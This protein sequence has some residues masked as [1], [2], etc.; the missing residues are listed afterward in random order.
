MAILDGVPV[1]ANETTICRAAELLLVEADECGLRGRPWSLAELARLDAADHKWLTEWGQA[2]TGSVARR[3]LDSW[4]HV[5]VAGESHELSAVTGLLFFVLISETARREAREGGLWS[6]VVKGIYEDS[7]PPSSVFQ[8]GQPSQFLKDAL[9]AAAVAFGLRHLFGQLG[10][11]NWFD[12]VYLQ[13][14]FTRAG[15]ERRL[16][17]WL[18]GQ[19]ATIAITSLRD[20]G[21]LFSKSFGGLWQ[22]LRGYRTNNLPLERCRSIVS[23]SPWTLPEWTDNLIAQARSRI[24]LAD[25]SKS[26]EFDEPPRVFLAEPRLVWSTPNAP[27]FLTEVSGLADFDLESPSYSIAIG[28]KVVSSLQRRADSTYAIL[29]ADATIVIENPQPSMQA[30]LLDAQGSAESALE[31]KLWDDDEDITV[32]RAV[33]ADGSLKCRRIPDAYGSKLSPDQSY[34]LL[35]ASDLMPRFE[36]DYRWEFADG[37]FVAYYVAKGW[38]MER[39]ALDLDGELLWRPATSIKGRS[40]EPEWSRNVRVLPPSR[41]VRVGQQVALRLQHSDDVEVLFVRCHSKPLDFSLSGDRTCSV[42]PITVGVGRDDSLLKM[43]IGLRRGGDHCVVRRRLDVPTHGVAFLG[44]TGWEALPEDEPLDARVARAVPFRIIPPSDDGETADTDWGL[45]EGDTYLRLV[46][47][48]PRPIGGVAGLGAPL[49][50]KRGPYNSIDP[51]M[52][53]AVAVVD[54]G[55]VKGVVRGAGRP[56]FALLV[57]TSIEPGND[58][59]VLWW[60]SLGRLHRCS[61]ELAN[62]A[63]EDLTTIWRCDLDGG[64]SSH[65]AVG[66]AYAGARVG[67]CWSADWPQRLPEAFAADPRAT[68]ALLR[69]FRLPLLDP[70]AVNSI[71]ALVHDHAASCAEA[72]LLDDHL[73]DGLQHQASEQGWFGAV[74]LLMKKARLDPAGLASVTSA[75]MTADE[76]PQEAFER[77]VRQLTRVD[78]FLMARCVGAWWREEGLRVHGRSWAEQMTTRVTCQL[79]GLDPRACGP[80]ADVKMRRLLIKQAAAEMG[81]DSAFVRDGLLKPCLASWQTGEYSNGVDKANV[82]LAMSIEPFRRLVASMLIQSTLPKN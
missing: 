45:L 73:D 78:P 17:E 19:P 50:L 14:G 59:C 42:E 67:A 31:L 7:S 60:D 9:E 65:L 34:V 48:R 43:K 38:D 25:Y 46:R 12:S 53:I 35:A 71:A 52:R 15:F 20:N 13:F 69:W 72:W 27:S 2:M 68:A 32:Y 74:R 75:F 64:V 16:P 22:A 56:Q 47:P 39:L 6:Y 30:R 49:R 81:V 8:Q 58:H 26:N 54:S 4:R 10:M 24:E 41:A 51:P 29:P 23:E 77:A 66:V 70:R 21:T 62:R 80:D 79:L 61:A 57:N 40:S 44:K 37:A 36:P 76:E 82:G 3:C 1:A 28:E 55:I 18:V 5:T 11:L 63:P 33:H